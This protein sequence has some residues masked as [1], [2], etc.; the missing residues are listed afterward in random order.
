MGDSMPKKRFLITI[1]NEEEDTSYEVDAIHQDN[2]I[3]YKEENNTLVL[4]DYDKNILT[5]ENEELRMDYHFINHEKT[6]GIIQVKE[7]GKKIIIPVYTRELNKD[8][9]N[10]E[11]KYEI[12]TK[13]FLYRIEERK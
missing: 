4:Y 9:N 13:E 2:K 7:L 3:K 1:K 12:E 8:N 6:S 11:I 10:V 5:R